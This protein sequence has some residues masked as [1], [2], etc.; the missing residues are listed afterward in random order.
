MN[1]LRQVLWFGALVLAGLYGVTLSWILLAGFGLCVGVAALST[2]G[3][4]RLRWVDP[5]I[6]L[7]LL[8]FG[9]RAT[10]SPVWDLA[11]EDILWMVSGLLVYWAFRERKLSGTALLIL[12][13]LTLINAGYFL[14]QKLGMKP[15]VPLAGISERS[16]TSDD[17]GFFQDYGALGNAMAMSAWLLFSNG[18]WSGGKTRTYRMFMIGCAIVASLVALLSGSRS[19]ILAFGVAGVVFALASLLAVSHLPRKVQ[20]RVRGLVTLG[21]VAG[22][23]FVMVLGFITFTQR[24]NQ[25]GDGGGGVESNIR[26]SYWGMAIEQALESPIYG[27]GAR[28]F[29]YQSII[30]WDGKLKSVEANPEFAHNEYLQTMGDYGILGL[31]LLLGILFAH[32]LGGFYHLYFTKGEKGNV[33]VDWRIIAGLTGLT[34]A[35]V[36]SLTDFP[37]RVPMN[38]ALA[39]ICLAWCVPGKT[40]GTGV[41]EGSKSTRL[42]ILM[43]NMLFGVVALFSI[44]MGGRELW[45]GMPLVN[46]QQ[47]REDGEWL[48]D[49]KEGSVSSFEL[50]NQRSPDFRR[51]LHQ[52]Q[53]HHARY[54]MGDAEAF[55]KAVAAYLAVRER[56]PFDYVARINLALLYNANGSF[57]KSDEEF[58]AAESLAAPRDWWLEFYLKW[59]RSTIASGDV[60]A[61]E[62]HYSQ[63]DKEY[64]KAI[65]LLD[66]GVS[67]SLPRKK[68]ILFACVS[69]IR[70]AIVQ[71]DYDRA[72]AL[73]QDCLR[74][75]EPW[76][77]KE[78]EV[79]IHRVL[80]NLYYRAGMAEWSKRKPELAVELFGR[81]LYFL[82]GDAQIDEGAPN[83][84]RHDKIMEVEKALKVLKSAGYE[85]GR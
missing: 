51:L 6:F 65:D 38:L 59:A 61:G 16:A 79:R 5:V 21:G 74:L 54:E 70:L 20:S 7:G 83:I 75:V 13:C 57:I 73:W 35:V 71:Q 30:H 36:N 67:K 37:L 45:A 33:E 62:G 22:L 68:L 14:M 26:T 85:L 34:V 24:A 82:K 43:S 10:N 63:A 49:G 39:A 31:L 69:R 2:C 23:I 1:R 60:S 18:V 27:T 46:I 41:L 47:V 11:K 32:Y 8:Y 44:G 81:T 40:F 48:V 64:A 28:S 80:G 19:A 15:W 66:Q 78:S 17:F 50:A 25:V 53:L 52:G 56:N 76:I 12:C 42:G 55:D 4:V 58:A 3:G 9:F 77:F 29:S 84:D 72:D